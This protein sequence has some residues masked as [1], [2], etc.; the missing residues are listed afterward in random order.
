MSAQKVP[1]KQ[2]Y[3]PRFYLAGFGEN[4]KVWVH[5]KQTGAY[6]LRNPRTLATKHHYYTVLDEKGQKDADHAVHLVVAGV[7]VP[8]ETAV[9][10]VG[11]SIAGQL[12]HPR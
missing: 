4:D 7:L 2:H 5:N 6:E 11:K 10:P 9:D 8:V 3:L 12:Y 1:K